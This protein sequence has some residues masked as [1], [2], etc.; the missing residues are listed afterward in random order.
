MTVKEFTF[1][2]LIKR[3]IVKIFANINK[4]FMDF[5]NCCSSEHDPGAPI[6]ILHNDFSEFII[7]IF[8]ISFADEALISSNE[9]WEEVGQNLK[10]ESSLFR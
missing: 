1:S 4:L 3:Q 8:V 9:T 6:F 5:E 2:Y 7:K 10:E